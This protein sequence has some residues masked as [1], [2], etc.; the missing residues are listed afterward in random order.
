MNTPRT[1][2]DGRCCLLTTPWAFWILS[3]HQHSFQ[4]SLIAQLVKNKTQDGG[5]EGCVLTFSWENSKI[6]TCGWTAID[7]KMLDP[8]KWKLSHIQQQ[9][10]SPSK[11]VGGTKS[12]LESNPIPT[13]DAQK[14]QTKP[15]VHRD[16]EIPQ[17]L[18]QTCLWVFEYLPWRQGSAVACCMGRSSGCRRPGSRSM[19]LK[20]SWRRS[21]L[22]PKVYCFQFF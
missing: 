19:W 7:R 18:S 10:G 14:V 11:T 16:P 15:C 1:F 13:R 9:R 2:L 22:T 12:H 6:T 5:V 8:T 20:P 3:A 4:A 17:R 21:P